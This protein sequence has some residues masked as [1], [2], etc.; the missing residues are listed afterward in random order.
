[1]AITVQCDIVSAE[2]EIFSGSVETLVAAGSYGDLGIYP[3]HAP[4]LTTLQ[5][6]PVRVIK[7][8]GEQ[9]VIF[10]SGG[11]LEV[12]PHRVTVLADTAIR[13][14]DLDEAAALEAQ[15]HAQDLL[16]QQ[17]SDLDYSRATAELAEAVARLRTIQQYRHVK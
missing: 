2:Q 13:A 14:D 10:V 8:N 5:P 16:N 12:Q 3:G 15:K 9:E 11:F 7:Q 6:G 17:Q 4:L 1:M